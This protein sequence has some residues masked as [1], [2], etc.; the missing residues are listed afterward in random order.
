MFSIKAVTVGAVPEQEGSG[1][2]G[3]PKLGPL[4][5]YRLYHESEDF[6]SEVQTSWTPT[7]PLPHLV[8]D[9]EDPPWL[10]NPKPAPGQ[11]MSGPFPGLY[12][13]DAVAYESLVI[14]MYTIYRCKG[15]PGEY[16]SG[17]YSALRCPNTAP[18]GVDIRNHSEFDS[19]FLGFSRDGFHFSRPGPGQPFP[20]RG[21]NS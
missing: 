15:G 2:P 11:H 19:L 6:F 1:K 7:E 16:P 20:A 18:D 9:A 14:G 5:R 12:N 8:A 4:D 3:D 17:Q 21:Y 10:G 13:F